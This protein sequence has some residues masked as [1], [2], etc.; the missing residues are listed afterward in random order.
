MD[1]TAI[2]FMYELCSK[3]CPDL[4][5]A[6]TVTIT[7]QDTRCNFIPNIITP[8]GD[9]LN[10]WFDIPCLET[11]EYPR[12]E[13]TIY[14]Q[15]GDKVYEAKPYISDPTHAWYG[16]LNGEKGKDLPDAVYFYV[17]KPSPTAEVEKGFIEIYR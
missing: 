7:V 10:D 11:G 5:S 14:N 13:L 4:C 17:L 16:E 6:A 8:N 9:D 15:W 1:L 12:N 3:G 2:T